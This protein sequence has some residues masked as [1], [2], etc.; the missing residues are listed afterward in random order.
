MSEAQQAP[1]MPAS[2]LETLDY[3]SIRLQFDGPLATITLN[4]SDRLNA[5]GEEMAGSIATAVMELSKPRRRVRAVL[6]TAEGRAFCAG[7][8]LMGTRKAVSEGTNKL[9]VISSL[10][11]LFHPMLRRLHSLSI[12][13]IVG[14]NG[15][16]IGV[17]L[18][19]VI[20]GDYII[21]SEAAW[22]QTPFKNLA[23]APDSG[24]TWLLPRIVGPIRAKRMLLR[25][26]RVDAQ[27]ALD[28]GL[29]S[30]VVPADQF[31][32][33]AREVAM[34]FANDATIALGEIKKL[35]NNGVRV[36]LNTALE[37]EAEAVARTART[38]DNVAAV[39]VFA[40]KNKPVFTG[41]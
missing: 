8:N 9:A 27:T 20:T 32:A 14:V 1:T 19:I 37:A 12:P 22:F 13:V 28:W 29:V 6:I 23:S 40:T 30:E 25:A 35:I 17:G 15:L 21:A 11:S 18:G 24:T 7:V 36:D 39:K 34:E 5:L 33:R 38:K 3:P 31:A 10:E 41:E 2:E 26:E 4:D 16:A